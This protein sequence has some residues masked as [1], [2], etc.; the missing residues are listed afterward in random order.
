MK[1]YL[2]AGKSEFYSL[3]FRISLKLH[4]LGLTVN[5]T[6]SAGFKAGVERII[7]PLSSAFMQ[8]Y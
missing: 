1:F 5:V 8:K 4:L 2:E 7:F 6:I 3:S